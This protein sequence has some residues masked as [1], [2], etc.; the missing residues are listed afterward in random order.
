MT[1]AQERYDRARSEADAAYEASDHTH[2]AV[3]KWRADVQR[4]TDTALAARDDYAIGRL[5]GLTALTATANE[6]RDR[7][8]AKRAGR[9]SEPR[10]RSGRT[11]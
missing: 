9:Q 4:A 2:D 3:E 7:D 5:P 10:K 6:I 11:R 1:Q 8:A